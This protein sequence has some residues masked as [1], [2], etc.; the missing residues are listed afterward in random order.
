MRSGDYLG[1]A[2]GS[3]PASPTR[4]AG[5]LVTGLVNGSVG[6]SDFFLVDEL[7]GL[8][9]DAVT[10]ATQAASCIRH[11]NFRTPPWKDFHLSSTAATTSEWL[12]QER[13]NPQWVKLLNV[14]Q[15]NVR[16]TRC[17]G[18]ELYAEDGRRYID[19]LSGYCVHN[20]GTIIP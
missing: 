14:L 5:A 11:L 16:Y 9:D 8:P 10:G 19:F 6:V 13:V 15:M 12:Y 4:D 18:T 17:Q 3:D 20:A 2:A 1:W 7:A